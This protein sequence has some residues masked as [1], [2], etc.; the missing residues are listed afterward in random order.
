MKE[1]IILYFKLGVVIFMYN[2]RGSTLIESLLAFDIFI[3]VLIVFVSLYTNL[4]KQENLL[5]GKYEMLL[6][7]EEDVIYETEFQDIINKVLH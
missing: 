2:R 4:N 3:S 5:E 6:Q 1:I 7:K